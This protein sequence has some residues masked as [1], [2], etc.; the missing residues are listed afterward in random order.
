M[1][2]E[3]MFSGKRNARFIEK[4]F[5]IV[6][7]CIAFFGCTGETTADKP[8]ANAAAKSKMKEIKHPNGLRLNAPENLKIEQ[9]AAGFAVAPPSSRGMSEVEIS[10]GETGGEPTGESLPKRKTIGGRVIEYKIERQASGGSGGDEYT[11][12]AVEKIQNR[13]VRYEQSDLSETGEPPF[14]F[15]WSIVEATDL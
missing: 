10:V 12:T 7:I 6:L 11:I 15:F 1:S 2:G 13:T 3:A 8:Q 14:D 4:C 5:L 9:T